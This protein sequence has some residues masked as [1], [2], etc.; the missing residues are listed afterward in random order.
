ML[1]PRAVHIS[2]LWAKICN[3]DRRRGRVSLLIS[4]SV[5]QQ[6]SKTPFYLLGFSSDRKQAASMGLYRHE[7]LATLTT[8]SSY[9][10]SERSTSF[11]DESGVPL[12]RLPH[13]P[14]EGVSS[15]DQNLIL[16]TFQLLPAATRPPHKQVPLREGVRRREGENVCVGAQTHC[17][18]TLYSFIDFLSGCNY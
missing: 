14:K 7:Y 4:P 3:T 2:I 13:A 10:P 12:H 16:L 6:F 15:L 11:S 5:H 17:D 8:H 1:E 18:I 9:K